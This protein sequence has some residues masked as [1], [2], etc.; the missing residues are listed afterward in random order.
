MSVS[1]RV[2]VGGQNSDHAPN[3]SS[4]GSIE[5]DL[6]KIGMGNEVVPLIL[7]TLETMAAQMQMVATTL[8]YEI[9]TTFA[10]CTISTRFYVKVGLQATPGIYLC[11]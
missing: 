9:T 4:P 3:F 6:M 1:F 8:R 5:I 7:D 10:L 11:S 2:D